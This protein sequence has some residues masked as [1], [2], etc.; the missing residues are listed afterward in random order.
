[1]NGFLE[2]R[3]M[4]E[5]ADMHN[6]QADQ[7]S[8]LQ[9]DATRENA[10]ERPAEMGF[11]GTFM[12]ESYSPPTTKPKY[13]EDQLEMMPDW[14][15]VSKRMYRVME[16]YEF[17]GSDK[18]AAAYGMDLMSEFN[19]NVTGPAGFPGEAGISSPGMIGQV[20]NI[21][22]SG[23]Y[24]DLDGNLVT[25]ENNANDF[26]F[27]LNTY[28]DTKTEGE[29]IKRSFRALF[30][31]PETYAT[32]AGGITAPFLKAAAM[33]TS[34]MTARQMLMAAA[35][36]AGFTTQLAKRAPGKSGAIAGAAYADLYEGANMILE[37]AAGM[38]PSLK[39][40]VM[41]TL[42]TSVVG[43][44]AGGLLGKLFGG[45]AEEV[46]PAVSRGVVAA[47]EAAEA[48]GQ[49]AKTVEE[50]TNISTT[51]PRVGSAEFP[52]ENIA[53]KKVVFVP[54]DM[55]DFGRAYEGLSE[56][57][58][59]PRALM[60]GSGYGTLTESRRQGLGFASL[61]PKIA[62]RIAESGAD[63]MLI[64]TMSPRAHRSNIDFA[65]ILHRQ[66]KAYADEGY[67]TPKNQAAIAKGLS[68]KFEGMPN[69]FSDEALP[70]LESKS[71]EVRAAVADT[72]DGATYRDLGAPPVSRMI[73]ET[74]N[75]TEAGYQIGQGSVLVRIDNK[76]PVDIRGM[77]GGTAHPSYPIGLFGEPVASI[78]YGVKSDDIFDE[79][80]QGK[81]A[82]GSTKASA[83]RAL[84][85]AL[86]TVELTP[87]RLAKIPTEQPG[88]VRSARQ[89]QL[90][91]DVK[92]G[93]WRTTANPVGPAQNRNPTG[94]GPAEIIKA[95]QENQLSASLSTYTKSELAAKAKSGELVFYGLGQAGKSGTEGKV[96]FGLAKNTD[97]SEYGATSPDLTPNETAIVGVM[98]NEAG[99]VGKGIGA[100]SI[101]KALQE[102]A[103]VLDCYAVPTAKNKGGFLPDYYSQF[104]FEEVDRIPY[105]E[106]YLRDPKFGGSEEKY[107]KITRQWKSTGWDES[108]GYPDLVIMKW[109]GDDSVRPTATNRFIAEGPDGLR[110]PTYEYVQAAS[111]SPQQR[112]G[113]SAVGEQ[114]GRIEGD[115]GGDRGRDGNGRGGMGTSL[116]RGISE[117]ETIDPV[118]RRALGLEGE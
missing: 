3:V 81:I 105:D 106:K 45:A 83:H 103:T 57:P 9:I 109:K 85:M 39:E 12:D 13:T 24:T 73:N 25:K 59:E 71:F 111:D 41:R 63:Y 50:L 35:K 98:N 76:A 8:F 67:I 18:Q 66:M 38:P 28:A 102:G 64:S 7:R 51:L 82:A 31:A 101:L 113:Q 26:L 116:Q 65:T 15:E 89:A 33:K 58:I 90:L 62:K 55:L 2:D 112:T 11:S 99:A 5:L 96:Y 29:T 78:P 46:A 118:S 34:S 20:W 115:A 4:D 75:P 70:W 23:G 52:V 84:T 22:N 79:F 48:G 49:T 95:V 93:N 80:L 1:M 27:L 19:W 54:A 42:T 97:Y 10:Q 32:V 110:R 114:G 72:I 108:A 92:Q 74:I 94:L 60:G 40:A 69:I 91:Q 56:A 77:E 61:D 47:G 36:T 17:I 88:F 14:I 16:G 44:G 117:L 37:T 21:V 53:G 104:G 30:G 68:E 100:A 6:Q 107:K 86:P 87:E 43:A